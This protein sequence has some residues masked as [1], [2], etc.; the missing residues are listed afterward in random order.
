MFSAQSRP[1]KRHFFL[2]LGLTRNVSLATRMAGISL[3]TAYRHRANDEAFKAEWDRLIER[4]EADRRAAIEAAILGNVAS[5]E[6][7]CTA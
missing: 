5:F 7:S 4:D 3:Q 2:M 1:W 6:P